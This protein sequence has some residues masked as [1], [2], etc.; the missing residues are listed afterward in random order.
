MRR[1][2]LRATELKAEVVFVSSVQEEVGSRG[3]HTS[4]YGVDPLIAIAV[5][6]TPTSDHPGTSKQDI[7]DI[8]LNGGPVITIGGRV[9]PRVYQ[10]L[11]KT[12]E[13][14]GLAWQLDPQASST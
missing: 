2:H 7:G 5:D 9:N 4:A 12:A 3:A 13:D 6:V 1:L 8:Q 10:L 11:V 14:A